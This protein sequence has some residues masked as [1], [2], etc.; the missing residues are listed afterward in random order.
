MNTFGKN[1][2]LTTFGESHGPAMGGVIDGF[3]AGFKIDFDALYAEVAKRRPGSSFLVTAR[4]ESDRPEFLSG[5]SPDGITL[6]TPIGFIVRNADHRSGDYDE[7][8]KVYRPNHADY[9]YIKRYGIRDARGGGRSSARETVNWVV[10]GALAS[11]WLESK[12]IKI[13]TALTQVGP[14]TAGDIFDGLMTNPEKPFK[15]EVNPDIKLAMEEFV[16]ETKIAGDSVGGRVSCLITGMP[17]GIGNPVA[18]KL[19]AA[20]AGAMMSINATK[21]FEYGIGFRAP[22]AKGSQIADTFLPSDDK[23]APLRTATNY[24]G[25]IQGGI[26]NGMPIFFSVAFKPTPTLMK[27]LNTVNTSGE[28]T[29]LNPAGRHDPCV[30]VRAVHVVKA[31]TALVLADYLV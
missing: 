24:S 12:G 27:P 4:N 19:H 7:M 17:P 5:I 9:T 11:Q 8:A 13:E 10:A 6:G 3:P 29:V 1:L 22:S 25:G 30:A 28:A 14:V 15:L 23:D 18:D 16:K 26:S 2:T 31:M 21:G 20:L